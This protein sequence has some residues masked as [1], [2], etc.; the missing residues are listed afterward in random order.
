MPAALITIPAVELATVGRWPA[1]T[2]V[3]DCTAEDLAAA[4][5]A[6]DDPDLRTPIVR[7]GHTDPRFDGEPAIGRIENL[8]LSAD[9]MTLV[10]DLVGV[11]AWLAE[12]MPSAF[13]S[14]SVEATRNAVTASGHKHRLILTG[15]ALLGV[16][17]PAI[18]RLA[19]VAALYGTEPAQI[20]ASG[21]PIVARLGAA[22]PKPAGNVAASVNVEDVRRAYY[23]RQPVSSW[24]WVREIWTDFLIVDD[25]DGGLWRVPFTV[26]T[27]GT[28]EQAVTFGTPTPVAVQYVDAPAPST[29]E[30]ALLSRRP[31]DRTPDLVAARAARIAAAAAD[32]TNPKGAGM[33]PEQIREALGLDPGASAIEV[34][35]KL[36]AL[37]LI[38]KVTEPETKVVPVVEP[39]TAPKAEGVVPDISEHPVFKALKESHDKLVSDFETQQTEKAQS[40]RDQFLGEAVSAGRLKPAERD[41]FA[42]LFDA[43]PKTTRDI[44]S[45]R[46]RGSEVPISETPGA[47]ASNPDG[48]IDEFD[49]AIPDPGKGF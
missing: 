35:A 14:R 27:E 47:H 37:D 25:D 34:A 30:T 20:I 40:E 28:G 18:E 8:R 11:P 46:K 21:E 36:A 41:K 5:M 16:E 44:I 38:P 31:P 19:D 6:A 24:A 32:P 12:I 49:A 26:D 42:I 15:L 13:P 23:D 9:G 29:E 2:G 1:S 7:L 39:E 3:W 4:V 10:G 22:M 43:D 48:F 33:S 45:A 17:L